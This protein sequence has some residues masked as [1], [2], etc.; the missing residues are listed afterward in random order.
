MATNTKH[1]NPGL[2]LTLALIALVRP[3]MS[4]TGISEAIGK[5]VASITATAIISI[6][7][8]AA[9][10]IRK[11]TQPVLTLVAAGVAYA[12]FAVIISGVLSPILAGSLQGP[13]TSPFAIVSVLL[14][15]IIWGLVTGSIAALLLNLRR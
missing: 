15:N 14:T 12:V 7:W 6:L 11:E 4:I 9:T 2:I 5:P 13:L 8:V 10:V 1:L 3:F